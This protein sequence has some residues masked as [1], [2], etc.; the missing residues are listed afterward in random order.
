MNRHPGERF[1]LG[2]RFLI[3]LF[4]SAC[5][6]SSS[7]TVAEAVGTRIQGPGVPPHLVFGCCDQGTARMQSLFASR[8]AIPDLIDLHAEVAVPILDFTPPHPSQNQPAKD[9][10]PAD[11]CELSIP[12][13]GIFLSDRLS[14]P[15][16]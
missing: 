7:W 9:G 16:P 4:V 14:E 10:V 3:L 1:S 12:C 2:C 13:S 5:N 15:T 8:E 11:A 6:L